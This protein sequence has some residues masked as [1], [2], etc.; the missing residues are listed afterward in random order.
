MNGA[1]VDTKIKLKKLASNS[2]Q[3]FL[4]TVKSF[5]AT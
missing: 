1:K 5:K 4:G 2:V 3:D